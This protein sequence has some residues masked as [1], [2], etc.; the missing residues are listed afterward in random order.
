MFVKCGFIQHLDFRTSLRY[1]DKPESNGL[2]SPRLYYWD[3][4]QLFMTLLTTSRSVQNASGTQV[5]N[6]YWLG[7]HLRF[8][9]F[10]PNKMTFFLLPYHMVPVSG[11]SLSSGL[12]PVFTNINQAFNYKCGCFFLKPFKSKSEAVARVYY[13][14]TITTWAF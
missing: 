12:K 2:E 9:Q 8:K 1:L 3:F 6:L 13:L 14:A 11:P 5:Q 7:N 10:S 4:L